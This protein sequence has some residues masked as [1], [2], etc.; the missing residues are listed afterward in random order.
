MSSTGHE[1]RPEGGSGSPENGVSS[2]L[3]LIGR[4]VVEAMVED[5]TTESLEQYQAARRGLPVL[6]LPNSSVLPGSVLEK[7]LM[8]QL[9]G[10][11]H[12]LG[13]LPGS[14]RGFVAS[15][16]SGTRVSED[17]ATSSR[18]VWVS[19]ENVSN[20]VFIRTDAP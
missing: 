9:V 10:S 12:S 5:W 6:E 13:E 4:A 8:Q 20:P 16:V 1:F 17:E 2:L 18:V 11:A 19:R 15:V 7:R 14:V 3:R